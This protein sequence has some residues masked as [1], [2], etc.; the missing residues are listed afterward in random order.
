[1]KRWFPIMIIIPFLIIMVVSFGWFL[2]QRQ[3]YYNEVV[4]PARIAVCKSHDMVY[5]SQTQ[6]QGKSSIT[7]SFCVDKKGQM[8]DVNTLWQLP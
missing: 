3:E 4:I 8:F 5:S 1:M 7:W 6:T 2:Y